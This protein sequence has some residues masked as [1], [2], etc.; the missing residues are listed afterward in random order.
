MRWADEQLTIVSS[1]GLV[2]L[3]QC[4]MHF[5]VVYQVVGKLGCLVII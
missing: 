1:R 3:V 2:L 5:M 4:Q